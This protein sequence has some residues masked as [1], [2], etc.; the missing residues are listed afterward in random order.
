MKK[1]Q[2][3]ILVSIVLMSFLAASCGKKEKQEAVKQP[4]AVKSPYADWQTYSYRNI[5]IVYPANHPRE[6]DLND[7]TQ[8]YLASIRRDCSVLNIPI[9]TDTLVVMY[10]T[11]PG[12]GYEMSKDSV[13]HASHDTIYFWLPGYYGVTLMQWLIPKWQPSPPA[14]PFLRH[15]LISLLDNSGQ[16]YHIV[17]NTYVLNGNFIPLDSLAYDTDIDSDIERLQSGEAASFVDFLVYKYGI[18]ALDKMWLSPTTFDST[19]TGLLGI[20]TDSLQTAWL[21]LVKQQAKLDN[22]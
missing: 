2:L 21:S 19:V 5:R 9:P 11:G 7:M 17:T 4:S 16:N 3:L 14:F 8:S 22:K 20:S 18:T 6:A 10:Y 1:S 15:G 13:P 12:Q